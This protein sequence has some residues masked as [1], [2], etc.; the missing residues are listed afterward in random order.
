MKLLIK[1]GDEGPTDYDLKDGDI[2]EV[3]PD[4]ASF[5]VEE[6][7]K[8]LCIQTPEYGGTQ[9]ELVEPEYGLG[10]R[11]DGRPVIRRMRKYF[12]YYP[13]VLTQDEQAIVRNPDSPAGPFIGRF[14]LADIVRK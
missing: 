3:R 13:A 5:G 12:V 9:S 1:I 11:P 6:L 14:D 2:L 7:K 10:Q 8:F 4:G